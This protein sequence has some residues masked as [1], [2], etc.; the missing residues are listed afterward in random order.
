MQDQEDDPVRFNSVRTGR[1]GRGDPH[2]VD[3]VGDT[4]LMHAVLRRRRQL[5]CERPDPAR[6]V[7]LLHR[8]RFFRYVGV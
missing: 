6:P 1:G 2:G 3:S 5:V 4:L 8:P 7:E